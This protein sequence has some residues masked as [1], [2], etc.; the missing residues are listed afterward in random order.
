MFIR[1]ACRHRAAEMSN[2]AGA[3]QGQQ[4]L[5]SLAQQA[6]TPP[7]KIVTRS[8]VCMQRTQPRGHARP[9]CGFLQVLGRRQ[10]QDVSRLPEKQTP[11]PRGRVP[12]CSVS[13]SC[14][15][16]RTHGHAIRTV[17]T[18]VLI[19]AAAYAA[20]VDGG[21][22]TASAVTVFGLAAETHAVA[23]LVQV[24]ATCGRDAHASML[25]EPHSRR[26]CLAA[27]RHEKQTHH[28]RRSR[29]ALHH[30]CTRLCSPRRRG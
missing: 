2:A 15:H 25:R 29:H 12:V 13:H 7:H 20:R 22:A 17:A 16:T 11:A 18:H 21:D 6:H 14:T 27:W 5:A 4:S 30:R 1:R 19:I 10:P 3:R 28:T 9:A 24:A 8:R 26:A 23:A